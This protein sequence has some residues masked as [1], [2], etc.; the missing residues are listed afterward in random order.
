[1]KEKI[2]Y[3]IKKNGPSVPT[4]VNSF[5]KMNSIIISAVMSELIKEKFLLVSQKRIGS[6][7]LYF[8]KG[9]EKQVRN[10]L[11]KELKIN[12]RKI[13]EFFEKNKSCLK[14]NLSPQY[15]FMIDNLRDFI[16]PSSIK[17]NGEEK[18]LYKLAEIKENKIL[19]HNNSM[20]NIK[21]KKILEQK[22]PTITNQRNN[23]KFNFFNK[24]TKNYSPNFFKDDKETKKVNA[25]NK[26]IIYGK[27]SLKKQKT[28]ITSS[29]KLI[30][31]YNPHKYTKNLTIK[32]EKIQNDKNNIKIIKFD[33]ISNNFFLRNNFIV[34]NIKIIKKEKEANFIIKTNYH[35]SQSY[36]V[37]YYKKNKLNENDVFKAFTQS[38]L[39]KLPC[40][41]LTKAKLSKKTEKLV[42][43]LK[44][45]IKIEKP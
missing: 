19:N 23:S 18:I 2:L 9:Q 24:P 14:S 1:M 10:R 36:F 43:K 25:V 37:K 5:L 44:G 13:L 12:E 4:E 33:N 32:R 35:I 6:S 27:N 30:K 15:R 34:L 11:R 3:Y 8:I 38:Y 29:S 45:L 20:N 22:K 17:L 21:T 39:I 7:P 26:N 42:E 40:I 28:K 41:I 16:V 31:N